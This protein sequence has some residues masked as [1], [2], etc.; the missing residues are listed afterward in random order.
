MI[1]RSGDRGGRARGPS[2]LGSE[3]C[4]RACRG[5][6]RRRAWRGRAG[7]EGIEC[8]VQELRMQ[9][10]PRSQ[11]KQESPIDEPR[12]CRNHV[13]LFGAG[14]LCFRARV[15]CTSHFTGEESEAGK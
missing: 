3:M 15:I 4:L 13:C 11:D 7:G 10:L 14:S 9:P 8:Q 6:S 2:E 12:S 5:R 1:A